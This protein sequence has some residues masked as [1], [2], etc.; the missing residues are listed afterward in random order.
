MSWVCCLDLL[1]GLYR[2]HIMSTALCSMVLFQV[3]S[4]GGQGSPW[5]WNNSDRQGVRKSAGLTL[6]DWNVCTGTPPRPLRS[7][8]SAASVSS[9]GTSK[10]WWAQ[11]MFMF[12][13]ASPLFDA[14]WRL[15]IPQSPTLVIFYD[16]S[17]L[18][19]TSSLTGYSSWETPEISSE[20]WICFTCLQMPLWN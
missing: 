16:P 8:F 13:T 18:F 20:P 6:T 4:A 19:S 15:K 10:H 11:A 2:W 1:F 12:L 14:W 17:G 5:A 7:E 3:S 9:H